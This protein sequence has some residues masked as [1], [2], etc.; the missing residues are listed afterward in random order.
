MPTSGPCP[1]GG[2]RG[3]HEPGTPDE[4]YCREVRAFLATLTWQQ[5]RLYA[6]VE[7][8]RLGRGGVR[9]VAELTGV[10]PP[11]IARGRRQLTDL[12]EGRPL[13]KPRTPAHGRPRV[14]HKYPALKATL[15]EMLSDEVAGSPEGEHKWMRS[16]ARKLAR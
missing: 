11:T 15:E 1:R 4:Q 9:R 8:N 12:L 2:Q 14:E 7:A 13:E 6:A 5:R 10:G 16:S 3:T